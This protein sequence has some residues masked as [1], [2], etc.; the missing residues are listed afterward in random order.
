MTGCAT[1]DYFFIH[2]VAAAPATGVRNSR[3]CGA[4]IRI[5]LVVLEDYAYQL[6]VC[7]SGMPHAAALS[8]LAVKPVRATHD[9]IAHL[10][11]QY[12]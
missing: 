5:S 3:R 6:Y 9:P 12:R 7:D 1:G 11:E 10:D 8:K 2:D 4:E